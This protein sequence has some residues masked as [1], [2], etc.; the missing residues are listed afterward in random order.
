MSHVYLYLFAMFALMSMA[1]F[2]FLGLGTDLKRS[3]K[4]DADRRRKKKSFRA[5]S[6]LSNRIAAL[7]EKV[8]S[9]FEQSPMPLCAC[10]LLSA[11][12]AV[13]GFLAGK[14]VFTSTFLSVFVAVLMSMLPLIVMSF[15]QNV[16]RSKWLNRLASSMMILSNSYLVT[17]DFITTVQDNISLLEYPKPFR[18]FL[19]YASLMD[20]DVK[21]ALRRMENS[22]NN[23]YFS[24]WVDSLILA[25]DDRSLRYVSV[26]VVATFHDA[27]QAQEESDAAMYAVWREYIITLCLIFSVPLIFKLVM[28][29]A[30]LTMTT[31]F[32]GQS[33]MMLLLAAVVFSV[34]KAIKINKPLMA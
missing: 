15:R 12:S 22:V 17:G 25:Q 16:T 18:D 30:Y 21:S 24:Q 33:L 34:F 5:Q 19:T 6:R 27:L 8:Q 9:V 11:A 23:P 7:K 14:V 20:N 10:M 26:T 4:S 3:A 2:L 13:G 28:Y 1:A 31:S 32:A 29:D